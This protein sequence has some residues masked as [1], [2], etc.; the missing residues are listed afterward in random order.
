MWA[1][2]AQPQPSKRP[3][4]QWAG[5]RYQVPSSSRCRLPEQAPLRK[6]SPVH[7][8]SGA[9]TSTAPPGSQRPA[10][11]PDGGHLPHKLASVCQLTRPMAVISP[12]SWR[13]CQ[14]TRPMAVISPASWRFCQLTRGM[15]GHLGHELAFLPTNSSDGRHLG[16]ELASE[17]GRAVDGAVPVDM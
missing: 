13:F 17:R 1:G 16:G 9:A 15:T 5:C 7:N 2:G 8:S 6:I 3:R 14:L 12:A 10:S 11:T 4:S